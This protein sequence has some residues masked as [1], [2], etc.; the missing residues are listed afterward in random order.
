MSGIPKVHQTA[1]LF[2]AA[3]AFSIA[4]FLSA[5]SSPARADAHL[6][7]ETVT[8]NW[9]QA[10]RNNDAEALE[11]LLADEAKIELNDL[12]IVQTKMNFWR[13]SIPGRKSMAMPRS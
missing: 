2:L 5:I 4:S 9:Y 3:F 1:R 7:S 10:L 6:S 8:T 12:D 11:Q 13:R